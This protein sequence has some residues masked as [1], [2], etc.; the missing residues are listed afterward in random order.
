MKE[1]RLP[2]RCSF[3]FACPTEYLSIVQFLVSFHIIRE[4]RDS[5]YFIEGS[6]AQCEGRRRGLQL[7]QNANSKLEEEK[8]VWI[9][10]WL[11]AVETNKWYCALRDFHSRTEEYLTRLQLRY[12]IA[13]TFVAAKR[14]KKSRSILQMSETYTWTTFKY[15]ERAL[16]NALTAI[17]TPSSPRS[18]KISEFE[19]HRLVVQSMKFVPENMEV[20]R[21]YI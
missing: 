20:A 14:S 7:P 8:R 11:P 6:L 10:G 5:R 2:Q 9:Y 1:V 13:K 3:L 17:C 18:I 12:L 15:W 19:T 21:V 4:A 16:E